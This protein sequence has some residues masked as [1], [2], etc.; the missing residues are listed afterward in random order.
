[1]V[2]SDL[3][4]DELI[5]LASAGDD[6]ARQQL[7]SRYRGRLRRMVAVRLDRRLSCRIDPS[8]VVQE[9]LMDAVEKLPN[10]LRERPLPFYPWLRRLTWERLVKIHRRHLLA[11]KRSVSREE[12]HLLLPD[13]SVAEL[14]R[15]VAGSG[16]SPSQ[17]VV[18]AELR[19]RVKTAMAQLPESD[20]ELLV[21]RYLEQL[22]SAEIAAILEIGESGAR[23][24]IRRALQ[25][26]SRLLRAVE[27]GEET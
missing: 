17:H 2:R 11:G 7:L 10:Y 18:R 5:A 26:L 8:D 22:S 23:M 1:M 13:E 16:T 14:A 15:R 27:S 25:R 21:M 24:R 3:D 12:Q 6:T 19:S 9:A 20:R 4:T